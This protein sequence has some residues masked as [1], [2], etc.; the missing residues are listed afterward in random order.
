[1]SAQLINKL[2]M[3]RAE[4]IARAN[5]GGTLIDPLALWGIE[6]MS[7]AQARALINA[8]P[9]LLAALADMVDYLEL[10]GA[11]G[12]ALDNARAAMLKAEAA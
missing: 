3:L 2:D 1:M 11:T 8:A 9:D 4:R 6:G 7:Q 10:Y 12:S 5:I